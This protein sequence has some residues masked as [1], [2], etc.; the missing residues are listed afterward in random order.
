MNSINTKN[1]IKFGG[2]L[3][4]EEYWCWHWYD[5]VWTNIEIPSE[6]YYKKNDLQIADYLL[7]TYS[8]YAE[9]G[10]MTIYNE[11]VIKMTHYYIDGGFSA[12]RSNKKL[13]DDDYFQKNFRK[14]VMKDTMLHLEK[15]RK[16][17]VNDQCNYLEVLDK[18]RNVF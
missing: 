10:Y 4:N 5:S 7:E 14:S 6:K 13:F 1:C 16:H 17:Y 9:G 15:K 8:E 18:G 12:T 11:I 3:F 2:T